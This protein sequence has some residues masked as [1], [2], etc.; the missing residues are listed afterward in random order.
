[1]RLS[2]AGLLGVVERTSSAA[3]DGQLIQPLLHLSRTT[4]RTGRQ[5][6]SSSGFLS[7][8]GHR[9][10]DRR[11]GWSQQCEPV[12][13]SGQLDVGRP[14]CIIIPS[15]FAMSRGNLLRKQR[16]VPPASDEE[17]FRFNGTLGRAGVSVVCD[18]CRTLLKAAGEA[19]SL[20]E[21]SLRQRPGEQWSKMS[22]RQNESADPQ[23][24]DEH[25]RAGRCVGRRSGLGFD[26]VHIGDRYGRPAKTLPPKEAET[27]PRGRRPAGVHLLPTFLHSGR[28]PWR[29]A[30]L[31]GAGGR[32]RAAANRHLPRRSVQLR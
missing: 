23:A 13:A 27:H 32:R 6:S 8:T 4:V 26:R 2:N 31:A 5:R 14:I 1:M 11:R 16:F 10:A 29:N 24:S 17:S 3:D 7:R 12:V 18:S 30:S 20:R 28:R 21:H 22:P 15:H 9:F 25:A 19:D